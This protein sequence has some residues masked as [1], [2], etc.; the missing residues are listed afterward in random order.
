MIRFKNLLVLCSLVY[1]QTSCKKQAAI[2]PKPSTIA[3]QRL[4]NTAI[5]LDTSAT[6]YIGSKDSMYAINATTGRPRWVMPYEILYSTPTVDNGIVYVGSFDHNIYALDAATGSLKWKYPTGGSIWSSPIVKYGNVYVGGD[7]KNVYAI[8]A[9][10]GSLKWKYP[11][12][13]SIWSS[14]I[15]FLA[16]LFIGSDDGNVYAINAFT[17]KIFWQTKLLTGVNVNPT[18]DLATFNLY[19][20]NTYST[21]GFLYALDAASGYINPS[22]SI[23]E[24]YHGSSPTINS[25]KVF[26]IAGGPFSPTYIY[27]IDIATN[28]IK[29][30]Y[31]SKAYTRGSPIV[32]NN[33]LY[34]GDN[35]SLIGIDINTG[36]EKW[37]SLSKMR[38]EYASPTICKERIYAIGEDSTYATYLLAVNLSTG[39]EKWRYP[40]K[41]HS[42]SSPCVLDIDGTVYHPGVSGDQP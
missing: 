6:V 17:G 31:P 27:G 8:D 22:V 11:T 36:V 42:G 7:D 28:T 39:V 29:W 30:K 37:R 20:S 5:P 26:T 3:A 10:S 4:V 19:V 23:A 40:I 12:S 14:P 33:L 25:G 32:Y 34:I 16:T 2:I 13:G 15:I 1:I 9:A 24:Q 21:T 38:F 41:N 18:I 35:E